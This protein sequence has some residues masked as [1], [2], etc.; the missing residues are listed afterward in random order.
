MTGI[1]RAK[2]F[3][4]L[5]SLISAAFVFLFCGNA[6]GSVHTVTI[7]NHELT[8][9]SFTMTVGDSVKWM[10]NSSTNVQV[11]CGPG[12][13]GTHM[14]EG[15]SP[16][17]VGVAANSTAFHKINTAGSYYYKV[18]E[19]DGHLYG[20][21]IVVA[22]LPVELTDFVATTIK[23]EVILDWATGGEINNERFEIQR[24]QIDNKTEG[25]SNLLFETIG[26]L[27]GLGNSSNIHNYTYV[28]RNL[29]TGIYLYRLKQYD[30]NGNFVYHSLSTEIEIGI[31]GKFRVSQNY[32]NPFNPETSI[33][34]D[35]PESGFLKA[36]LFDISGKETAIVYSNSVDAGYKVLRVSGSNL[37]SGFYFCRF[38]FQKNSGVEFATKK[39]MLL[40]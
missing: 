11:Q 16:F 36:S 26:T 34:V 20:E 8:P 19:T 39:I 28:D 33:G 38:E 35:I 25:S 7:G 18:I 23:N 4:Q 12:F 27:Q 17:A 14:P 31:P 10:N 30:Y 9:S 32:P 40:K 37:N 24:V 21:I 3:G 6:I 22:P 29:E 2:Q 1:I 13:A 15:V 5:L